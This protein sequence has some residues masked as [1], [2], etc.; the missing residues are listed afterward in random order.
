MHYMKFPVLVL[1]SGFFVFVA[2]KNQSSSSNIPAHPDQTTVVND[3][4]LPAGFLTFYDKFHQDSLFQLAHIQ[5]PLRG[6]KSVQ[7]DSIRREK[8]LANW[9][10]ATWRIQHPVDFNSGEFKREWEKMGDEFVIERIKYAAANYGLERHFIRR[11]DGEWELIYY[12]DM[13]EMGQ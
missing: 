8:Q 5:W 2:C 11:D 13:Q 1:V 10:A 9:E 12:A 6:E 4:Q 3:D 7:I